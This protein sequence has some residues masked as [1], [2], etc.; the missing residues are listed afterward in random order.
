MDVDVRGTMSVLPGI[1]QPFLTWL[2]GKALPGQ[3]ASNHSPHGHLLVP[4]AFVIVGV[5]A[6]AALVSRGL[7]MQ[8]GLLPLTWLVTVS[9]A[10]KLQLM[11]VHQCAHGTFSGSRRV[12]ELVGAALSLLLTIE[13]FKRYRAKHIELHHAQHHMTR[14]DPTV[15]FLFDKVGLRPGMSKPELWRRLLLTL[16][17]PRYH[18]GMTAERIASVA[19]G[20]PSE[21][22]AYVIF[23]GAVLAIVVILGAELVFAVA[24]LVPIVL[25]YNVSSCL[26]LSSEHLWPAPVAERQP[27][28]RALVA[29]YSTG[30]FLGEAT[31][32]PELGGISAAVA[33]ARWALRML[34]VHLPARLF[35]LVGDTPCHD[36]HH[37]HPRSREWMN[38][39]YARQKDIDAGAPGWPPYT[40]VWGFVPAL[41]AALSALSRT[42]ETVYVA[43]PA[44]V[45]AV[46]G[47]SHA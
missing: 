24:W 40:E 35:V 37:R 21:L 47:A 27:P 1:C 7:G 15:V 41:D 39:A 2:T 32:S 38:Y 43:T 46:N 22:A 23:W 30:I 26:R 16:V 29:S 5:A 34:F 17:S 44:P 10:R 18:L 42:C 19:R 25:L 3:K 31:P 8:L 14:R 12:N 6:S 20:S 13:P 11:I 33:W 45:R 36:Y 28:G 4:G 9:G